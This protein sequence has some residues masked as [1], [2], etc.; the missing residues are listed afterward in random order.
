MT[1]LRA[2]GGEQLCHRGLA[3]D[4]G[5]AVVLG[6]GGAIDQERRCIDVER[7]FGERC[8]HHLQ[9]GERSAEQISAFRARDGFIERAAGE[10]ERRGADGGAENI[11]R[12]H[13]DS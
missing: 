7:H 6:P 8:L 3:G 10:T 9:I 5:G 2:L 4:A 12:R 13:G 11:E 1:C